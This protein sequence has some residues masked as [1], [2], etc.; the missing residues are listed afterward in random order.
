MNR[1]QQFAR[2]LTIATTVVLIID[3][4]ALFV[5]HDILLAIISLLI[6]AGIGIFFLVDW[7]SD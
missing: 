5:Y 3:T 6:L 4:I 7:L 1:M 2:G